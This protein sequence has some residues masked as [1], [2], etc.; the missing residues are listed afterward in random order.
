AVLQAEPHV[1]GE[2]LVLNGD[3]IIEADLIAE[4]ARERRETFGGTGQLRFLR[5]GDGSWL[6]GGTGGEIQRI[7]RFGQPTS[8]RYEPF[9]GD[10]VT[11]GQWGSSHW[12][13]GSENGDLVHLEPGSFQT[14][15]SVISFGSGNDPI[16]DILYTNTKWWA[17]TSSAIAEVTSN[18]VLE[19]ST[20]ASGRTI[21]TAAFADGTVVVGSEDG[22][23]LAAS[24]GSGL[25]DASWTAALD[26]HAVRDFAWNGSEWLAVGDGGRLRR[27][28]AD[29]AP[30]GSVTTVV[31][32]HDIDAV[33]ATDNGW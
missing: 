24:T 21:T 13:V 12:L 22:H 20:I 18:Q 25:A 31:N 23:V 32:G 28:G 5:R 17:L 2:F 1:E 19:P 6:A 33:R 14:R 4:V 27:L 3:R 30:K 9:G 15:S 16:V 10:A 8:D 7:D 26:G 11:A 29:R